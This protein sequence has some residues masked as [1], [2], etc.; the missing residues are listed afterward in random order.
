MIARREPD[1]AAPNVSGHRCLF[2]FQSR[3]VAERLCEQTTQ[4]AG[5]PDISVH[6]IDDEAGLREL[7][8]PLSSGV[9]QVVWY[10][11]S[12]EGQF[13]LASAND[14]L[15]RLV[16]RSAS[17]IEAGRI[18]DCLA[19][20]RRIIDRWQ[21]T[22][23]FD[24]TV[25]SSRLPARSDTSGELRFSITVGEHRTELSTRELLIVLEL[26][27][28]E[29]AHRDEN[30]DQAAG[31][32]DLDVKSEFTEAEAFALLTGIPIEWPQP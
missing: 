31:P 3:E 19:L 12:D 22:G 1:S 15:A 30:P 27:R 18:E 8:A 2:L 11:S 32:A 7:L 9:N 10:P 17:P 13:L 21:E 16:P 20:H 26:V 28:Q 14:F 4:A 23:A 6:E 25:A 29:I 5:D 24:Y